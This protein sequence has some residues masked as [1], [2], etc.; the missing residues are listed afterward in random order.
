MHFEND[1]MITTSKRILFISNKENISEHVFHKKSRK[2][3]L[4]VT[5]NYAGADPWMYKYR[6]NTRNN[7]PV[8]QKFFSET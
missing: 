3:K 1:F 5:T 6:M 7:L 4:M 2:I 8:Q